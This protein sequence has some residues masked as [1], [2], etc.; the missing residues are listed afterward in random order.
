LHGTFWWTRLSNRRYRQ[1][2]L[3]VMFAG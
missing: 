1:S 3:D 2:G